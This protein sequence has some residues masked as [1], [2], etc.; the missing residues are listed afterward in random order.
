MKRF[1]DQLRIVLLLAVFWLPVSVSLLAGNGAFVFVSPVS[2]LSIDGDL[3]DWPD[4][5]PVQTVS[6]LRLGRELDGLNDARGNFRLGYNEAENVLYLGVEFYDDSHALQETPWV[7]GSDGY[8]GV[9]IGISFES[10]QSGEIL[11]YYIVN[12]GAHSK[13][14]SGLRGDWS[15]FTDIARSSYT[16]QGGCYRTEWRLDLASLTG[17]RVQLKP[18][19][20]FGFD[21]GLRDYDEDHPGEISLLEWGQGNEK[22]T[23]V[24]YGDALVLG[25]GDQLASFKGRLV[26]VPAARSVFR[27]YLRLKNLD[28]PKWPE[29][30]I[31]ADQADT[32]DAELVEGN[33]KVVDSMLPNNNIQ[34][35]RGAEAPYH[36][37]RLGK[38]SE[39]PRFGQEY[40]GETKG[41]PEW[42]SDGQWVALSLEDHLPHARIASLQA[43]K[44]QEMWIGTDQGIVHFDGFS[45][46]HFKL[47]EDPKKNS[48]YAMELDKHGRLWAATTLGGSGCRP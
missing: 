44:G 20:V 37:I 1:I 48:V 31:V 25:N 42:R 19:G 36:R 14:L 26:D 9:E 34:L 15:E 6:C 32:F 2:N 40:A 39:L 10:D 23:Y 29:F 27:N 38:G 45:L 17:S 33:Y 35:R 24:G 22:F 7:S 8:D 18:G 41:S 46:T 21:L 13:W 4:T 11:N 47:G 28:H 5:V 43:G 12:A 16:V 30:Q 3:S